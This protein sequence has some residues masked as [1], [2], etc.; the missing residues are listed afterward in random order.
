MTRS[1]AGVFA[2]RCVNQ[3]R[4]RDVV[5][6]LGLRYYLDNEAA[7]SDVW[8][9]E[10]AVDLIQRRSNPVYFEALHFKDIDYAGLIGHRV[11]HLPG[12]NEALAEAVL[13]N[14]CARI[15]GPFALP[16]QVFSYRI[17]QGSDTTGVFAHYLNGLRERNA[18][19]SLACH[20][21]SD[22]TVRV[23]D[24]KG[25]YSSVHETVAHGAWSQACD[26]TNI[27]PR[28]RLLGEKILKDYA[29]TA[30]TVGQGLLTGPMFSH[31]M[32]NL[33]LGQVDAAYQSKSPWE[34][35][36][37]SRCGGVVGGGHEAVTDPALVRG[38]RFL[39]LCS[40]RRDR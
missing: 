15:G 35:L 3:Y 4:R 20:G 32:A 9:T 27:A 2:R 10:V 23:T 22:A 16:D 34:P 1:R 36:I 40:V 7:R 21:D 33:V 37:T 25:F 6:Y 14:E 30:S 18:E 17:A 26:A 8:A 28:F 31:F 38:S 19:I 39:P 29:T 24:I 11:M 12:P 13:L 5:P